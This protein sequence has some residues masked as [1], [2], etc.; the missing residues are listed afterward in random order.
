MTLENVAH[1]V[2]HLEAL[3]LMIV[4]TV[5]NLA[6]VYPPGLIGRLAFA[7][8]GRKY[9]LGVLE[10][11]GAGTGVLTYDDGAAWIAVDSGSAVLA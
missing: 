4:D 3:E 9:V 11:P 1:R 2:R 7:T 8:D 5:A 10:G 6:A